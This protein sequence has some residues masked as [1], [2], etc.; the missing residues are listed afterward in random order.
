M[1]TSEN[2]VTPPALNSHSPA[3]RGTKRS[4]DVNPEVN[5]SEP[6]RVHN[7]EGK[8]VDEEEF[9]QEQTEN[10]T[11]AP[12]KNYEELIRSPH[13]KRRV[14]ANSSLL[15]DDDDE[16][17]LRAWSQDPLFTFSDYSQGESNLKEQNNSAVKDTS[18]SESQCFNSLQ[19]EEAWGVHLDAA[20]STSTQN[21]L[22]HINSSPLDDDKENAKFAPFKPPNKHRTSNPKRAH[23]PSPPK[24]VPVHPQKK[25]PKEESQL[26]R[27]KPRSSPVKRSQLSCKGDGEDSLSMLFTQDSEGFRVIAHGATLG[28]SP[29]K[30]HGNVNAGVSRTRARKSLPEEAEEMLFT[31]DSQGNVVIKH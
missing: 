14:F 16:P 2:V 10:H 17:R 13:S 1:S 25:A 21:S 15:D 9:W 23:S 5:S 19:S 4:R 3:A 22:K 29:L 26:A 12:N 24:C 30:D 27:T 28:R 31:Q 6:A 20:A 7:L 8:T 11:P 18:H